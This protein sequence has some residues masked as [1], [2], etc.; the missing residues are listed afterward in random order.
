MPTLRAADLDRQYGAMLRQPP[1]SDLT[2]ARYV[3]RALKAKRID[4]TEGVVKQWLLKYRTGD[5]AAT[6]GGSI[7]STKDLLVWRGAPGAAA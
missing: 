5:A 4:V 3:Q 2:S 6:G 1:L 7:K